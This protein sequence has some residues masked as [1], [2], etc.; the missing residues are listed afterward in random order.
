MSVDEL[1]SW[2]AVTKVCVII[3]VAGLA[4]NLARS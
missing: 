4:V 2:V 1:L 3:L